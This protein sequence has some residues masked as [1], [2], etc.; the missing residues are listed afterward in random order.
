MGYQMWLIG[1]RPPSRRTRAMRLVLYSSLGA[2]LVV[3]LVWAT[4]AWQYR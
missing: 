3:A 4:W 2:N 1:R